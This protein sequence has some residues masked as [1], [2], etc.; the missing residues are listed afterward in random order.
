MVNTIWVK[1][2]KI[3][4][5]LYMKRYNLITLYFDDVHIRNLTANEIREIIKKERLSKW[6]Y[7]IIDGTI[8]KIF[9]NG[10]FDIKNLK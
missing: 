2:E 1:I 8:L 4:E 3:N 6:D 10:S 9:D 5:R 7:A